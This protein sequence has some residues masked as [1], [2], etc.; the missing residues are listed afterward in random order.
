MLIAKDSLYDR[1]T[2][3]PGIFWALKLQSMPGYLA[4]PVWH[5]GP[6]A[7]ERVFVGSGPCL[8]NRVREACG[9]FLS[10]RFIYPPAGM[11]FELQPLCYDQR[12]G[13]LLQVHLHVR[14]WHVT[15][16]R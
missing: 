12:T 14:V 8:T 11:A 7:H 2:R 4:Y 15:C 16:T 1:P 10:I 5:G 13:A 9:G 3:G 6:L